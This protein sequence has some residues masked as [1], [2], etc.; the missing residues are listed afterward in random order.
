MLIWNTS[1]VDV[2]LVDRAGIARLAIGGRQAGRSKIWRHGTLLIIEY[3]SDENVRFASYGGSRSCAGAYARSAGVLLCL[4]LSPHA[5]LSYALRRNEWRGT[6]RVCG[7]DLLAI[8]TLNSS[9]CR[10]V[11]LVP[12]SKRLP[13]P[14]LGLGYTVATGLRLWAG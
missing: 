1:A 14:A 11:G 6:I 4:G 3:L 12:L 7:T 8:C 2:F 9:V 13:S 10:C 5:A